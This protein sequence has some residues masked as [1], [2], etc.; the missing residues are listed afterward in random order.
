[1]KKIIRIISSFCHTFFKH[2]M[3]NHSLQNM[4]KTV[5][6]DS[7]TLHPHDIVL[8]RQKVWRD[9]V[10][11]FVFGFGTGLFKRA[12][13][14]WGTLAGVL[15]Y[16]LIAKCSPTVYLILVML[17]FIAGV[18]GCERVSRGLKVHDYSG[19]VWDEVVGYLLT[20]YAVPVHVSWTIL[21]FVLFRV[22]DIWKPQPI[23]WIDQR[24]K[25]GLGIML[26]D[27]VAA[28]PAWFILHVL[29]WIFES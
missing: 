2:V 1:M 12:P 5:S 26:D 19:I 3:S 20:M 28:V 9:P 22:F 16:L 25:G 23:G 4:T 24:V 21:G 8:E 29:V 13:G 15:V 14:T 27:V 17:A 6:S 7:S 11:F 18:W 10:Y